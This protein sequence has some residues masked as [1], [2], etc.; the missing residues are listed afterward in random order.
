MQSIPMCPQRSDEWYI[1][2]N[3][4]ITASEIAS[5]LMMTE[6]VC[7]IYI[8]EYKIENFKYNINKC[9]SHFDTKEEYIINKCKSF[10]GE[11]VFKDSIYTLWGKKYEAIATRLYKKKFNTDILEFGFIP[12]QRL[13]YI[14]MSPDGV[15]WSTGRLLEI[16]CP[17]ARK[18]QE[19]IPPQHYWQQMQI[20]LEVANLQEC[21]FLECEI[22]ELSSEQIFCNQI[23]T[24]KQDKGILLNIEDEPLNSE[25]KYIYPP[26]NLNTID[27]FI[28]WKNQIINTNKRKI[29]PI[30]YFIEKW[31]VLNVKRKK[32]WFDSI[33]DTVKS[34]YKLIR[35]LQKN[36]DEFNKYVEIFENEKNKDFINYFNT[37]ECL[38]DNL[39]QYTSDSEFDMDIDIDTHIDK[40]KEENDNT[41][42]ATKC[43]IIDSTE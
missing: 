26:D 29:I 36:K 4:R 3:T 16:K 37:T 35:K 43:L 5:C 25:V 41:A 19:G 8:D 40:N 23:C 14:G 18:I 32:E 11:N 15:A 42:T 17:F 30:Y 2:R 7:K 12:H 39:S 34:I 28:D 22:K 1:L 33:K 10:Y 31:N 21:D 38:I 6:Q 13:K 27:E 9:C 24:E 20:Q